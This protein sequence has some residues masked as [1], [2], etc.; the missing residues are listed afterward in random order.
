[1]GLWERKIHYHIHK[2]M[3]PDLVLNHLI[4]VHILTPSFFK[5]H[6]NIIHPF[7]SGRGS[8]TFPSK[9]P[10]NSFVLSL[11]S[12][13]CSRPFHLSWF[14]KPTNVWWRV[15]VTVV[16]AVQCSASWTN[17]LRSI[18]FNIFFPGTPIPPKWPFQVFGPT[19]FMHF[20][21]CGLWAQICLLR[22][23][24]TCGLCS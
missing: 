17:Y 14:G 22:I 18:Y 3:L 6:F 2:R 24:L 1:M 5:I 10:T 21:S 13:L 19:C 23:V 11:P 20:S 15:Q 12:A 8:G 16:P 7:I 9:F 4:S